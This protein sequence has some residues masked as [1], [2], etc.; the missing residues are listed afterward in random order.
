MAAELFPLRR[1]TVFGC[2]WKFH[3][4]EGLRTH[5]ETAHPHHARHGSVVPA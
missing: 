4:A 3:T 1:C 2:G 5:R